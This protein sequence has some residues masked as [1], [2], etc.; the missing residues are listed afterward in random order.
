[1]RR[2]RLVAPLLVGL[3]LASSQS[4]ACASCG[5][6]G[7]DPLIL[8]PNEVDKIYVGFA[9]ATAFKN[10]DADGRFSTSGGPTAKDTLT[11]A[12]GHGLSPRAF[13]TGTLPWLRNSRQEATQTS[14]GDPSLA[15]RY[16]LVMASIAEPL[17]PQVQIL[18][19]Y[20]QSMTHSI[21]DSVDLKTQ[22][23]VFGTGFSEAKLGVYVWFGQL[24]WLAGAAF[25]L[26][27]P[28]PHT[29]DGVRYE[30]GLA[31]RS[32]VTVGYVFSPACKTTFGANLV[33]RGSLRGDGVV[34]T[35][36]EQ[37]NHSVFLTQDWLISP[38]ESWRLSLSRQAALG[39]NKNT[40]RSDGV[41]LAYLRSW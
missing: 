37:L 1:M 12:Y 13:V 28:L 29:Y 19:G 8:Y 14:L 41:S 11:L 22:L 2:R 38:V 36:S 6:G 4:F 34:Q 33:A 39:A 7:D 20:K 27:K 16:A 9:R 21:H 24:E 26:I 32:T 31:S 15:A 23:D 30:P 5:S 18:V 35:D 10:V 17:M 25:N 40:A 3:L